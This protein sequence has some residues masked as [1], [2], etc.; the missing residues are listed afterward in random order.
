V[1]NRT[2]VIALISAGTLWGLT[3]GLSKLSLEWLSPSWL[4]VLRFLAATPVLA[5][6]GRGHIRAAI[7]PGVLATGALGFGGAVLLQNVG[8]EHTSV[9]HAAIIVGALPVIV[10]LIAAGLGHARPDRLAWVGF[11]VALVGIVLVAKGGGGGATPIGD[12]LVLASVGLS[13]AFIVIQPRLLK[14]HNEAAVTA[15]EFAAGGIIALPFALF[16]S[17]APALPTHFGPV[18]AFVVLVLIGTVLPFW[19]F[20]YGQ[21][22]VSADIAGAFVNLEPLVGAAVGWIAFG[23]PVGTWQVVGVVAAIAG[24]LLSTLPRAS[25]VDSPAPRWA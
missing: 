23:D 18:L 22:R 7:R 2:A 4:T 1:K 10:A 14:G 13:A 19:L 6:V 17:G 12:L 11:T 24:I 21:A 15:V 20:A 16:S 5:V 3:V 25:L 9:S 8:I